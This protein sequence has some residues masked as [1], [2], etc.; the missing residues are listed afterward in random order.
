MRII[1]YFKISCLISAF[2][3]LGASCRTP[4]KRAKGDEWG[5]IHR[6]SRLEI[7][8]SDDECLHEKD[9]LNWLYSSSCDDQYFADE[10]CLSPEEMDGLIALRNSYFIDHFTSFER[11][12][13][14]SKTDVIN[15]FKVLA[16]YYQW[17]TYTH[18]DFT[19][20]HG[21]KIKRNLKKPIER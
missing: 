4:C 8:A 19:L 2:V 3:I 17:K 21:D 7:F 14:F 5:I 16:A 18:G 1:P 12:S 6:D 9:Y 20:H 15:S 10:N 13:G 11:Y